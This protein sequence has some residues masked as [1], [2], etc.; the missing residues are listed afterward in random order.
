M[1]I[2]SKEYFFNHVLHTQEFLLQYVLANSEQYYHAFQIPKSGGTRTI[3]AI[4]KKSL[5][6]LLQKNLCR[7]FLKNIPLPIPAIGFV[8]DESYLTFLKPHVGKKYF[9][10]LDIKSFFDTITT[11]MIES[12]FEEFFEAGNTEDLKYLS[13]ICTLDGRLPQGAVTSPAVSNIV[14]RRTDQ[15]ILKY[16]Q[17]FD[18][19]YIDGRRLTEDI[20]YTRYAD[21]M[22]F[23]SNHLDFSK[24]RYF[25]GMICGI[26]KDSG[27]HLNWD[28]TKTGQGAISLSGFVLSDNIH[29]SRK[30][31]YSLNRL[32]HTLGKT[33]KYTGKKYRVKRAFFRQPDWL[34][35]I[36][37]LNLEDG[38][39]GIRHFRSC[40]D[41]L[42]YLCG[43]RAFLLSVLKVNHSDDC[44]M[45]QLSNKVDK[46]E[47]VIDCILEC[48]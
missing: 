2:G 39:G 44:N 24:E 25:A 48:V 8:K 29:L 18:R 37:A 43:Y 23:S 33:Q 26:L 16:C 34:T 5:L 36:N 45:R 11:S 35:Q 31:L 42:N 28:K 40:E 17:S 22:L 19:L 14:F 46:L 3:Q 21:D 6:Y 32:L 7:N 13:A 47:A 1:F 27:F 12:Q 4:D 9:L 10:R 41:L 30:K 15:R 38:R 20:C